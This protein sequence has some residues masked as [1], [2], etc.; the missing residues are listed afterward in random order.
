MSGPLSGVKVLEIAGI[1]PGP[2]C[3]MLL[4]DIR[5]DIGRTFLR[6]IDAT[7]MQAMD[8]VFAELEGELALS[9]HQDF[10][11]IPVQFERFA[12]VRFV[13]QFH[14]VRLGL[15]GA[16]T[17]E[18]LLQT[19]RDSYRERFGHASTV[20]HAEIVSLQCAIRAS[21]A[22][23]GIASLLPVAAAIQGSVTERLVYHPEIGANAV[24]RVYQ[25][26]ALGPGFTAAGPA[27]IEEYGSTTIVGTIDRFEVGSL[28]ELR[29]S[30]A[31][32][33]T[34]PLP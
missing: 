20:A 16:T 23:P 24:T 34:G 18:Q 6:R 21:T 29:I 31:A 26:A 8:G 27:V 1:G 22:K 4:A 32:L 28:G 9:I 12:D 19:F 13:G 2:F 15:G 33:D 10:G 14:T 30:V 25:R 3:G 7:A 5:R 11:G 17:A